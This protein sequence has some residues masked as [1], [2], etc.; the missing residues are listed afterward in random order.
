[1]VL[2][3]ELSRFK[4]PLSTPLDAAAQMI[5]PWRELLTSTGV[6][7]TQ[8]DRKW[9]AHF[10][11][12]LRE[13]GLLQS[14]DWVLPSISFRG[15]WAP[16]GRCSIGLV[17]LKPPT[18]VSLQRTPVFGLLIVVDLGVCVYRSSCTWDPLVLLCCTDQT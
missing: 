9:P 3:D 2:A 12:H 13:K 5:F 4:E 8:T 16:A 6:E 18:C 11:V 1:M 7:I 14:A 10:D 17:L 15:V